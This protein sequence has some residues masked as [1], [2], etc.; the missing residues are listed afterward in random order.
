MQT[1][2]ASAISSLG[3]HSDVSRT[4]SSSESSS[5]KGLSFNQIVDQLLGPGVRDQAKVDQMIKDVAF[6]RSDDVHGLATAIGQA[7]LSFRKVLEIRNKV[8]D[9]YQE[10][11]RMQV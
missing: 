9:A 8:Q 4:D 1:H 6:G 7:D 5:E 3:G 2:A 11:M 10:V